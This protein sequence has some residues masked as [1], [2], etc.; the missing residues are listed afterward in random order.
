MLTQPSHG[1]PNLTVVRRERIKSRLNFNVWYALT[2]TS[3]LCLYSI[4]LSEF[5]APLP[6]ALW[7][8]FVVSILGSLLLAVVGPWR[9]DSPGS[10]QIFSTLL[11][12]ST[13]PYWFAAFALCALFLTD[14]VF[15]GGVPLLA[16]G[17]YRGF[18]PY[19]AEQVVRGIPL[20]HV[21]LTALALFYAILLSYLFAVTRRRSYIVVFAT[22][23]VLFFLNQSRGLMMISS[24]ALVLAGT[25]VSRPGH[26]N[27]LTVRKIASLCA[28]LIGIAAA[29]G[30]LGNLR[31]GSGWNDYSQFERIA[32]YDVSSISAL[33]H[34]FT[35]VYTYLT[36]PLSNLAY[37]ASLN[38]SES[39]LAGVFLTFVPDTFISRLNATPGLY[40]VDY[41]NASTGFSEPL[42]LSG[43]SG[44]YLTY[45]LSTAYLWALCAIVYKIGYLVEL[46]QLVSVIFVV[47][48]AF[49]SP[50][51]NVALAYLPALTVA[52]A[53]CC[54]SAAR[55]QARRGP[56]KPG[57]RSGPKR[58]A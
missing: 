33:V 16:V 27:S 34:P 12:E 23:M 20:V 5:N 51:A 29:A 42:R 54:R 37:V 1:V 14:W 2:W 10:R 32:G 19:R 11:G 13:R 24:L 53:L 7:G 18:D 35:W 25:F 36:S 38:A 57:V 9:I 26:A 45:F 49:Y 39:D 56:W 58:A 43:P 15:Q 22:I 55:R 41:L 4:G 8:F 46:A 3:I 47:S 44:L 48:M 6:V 52:A 40:I 28:A 30:V 21:A 31:V 17:G 50:Y